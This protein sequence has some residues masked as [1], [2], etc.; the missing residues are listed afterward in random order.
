MG[1]IYDGAFRTILNRGKDEA[2]KETALRMF[3]DGELP[4]EKVAKYSGLDITEVELFAG[5]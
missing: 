5:V 4:I 2:K 3:Q 1:N